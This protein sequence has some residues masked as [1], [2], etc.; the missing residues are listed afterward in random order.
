ML[1]KNINH[2]EGLNKQ[3]EPFKD[4]K[5]LDGMVFPI[6]YYRPD[7]SYIPVFESYRE[8]IIQ[9]LADGRITPTG[10]VVSR[11]NLTPG[12]VSQIGLYSPSYCPYAGGI[13]N[14]IESNQEFSDSKPYPLSLLLLEIYGIRRYKRRFYLYYENHYELVSDE[15]LKQIIRDTLLGLADRRGESGYADEILKELKHNPRIVVTD[16]EICRDK[17]AFRNCCF[18]LK[19]MMPVPP[20]RDDVI[21]YSINASFLPDVFYNEAVRNASTPVFDGFLNSV[22]RHDP[23]LS[24]RIWQTFGYVI[25]PDNYGRAFFVLQGVPASGKSTIERLLIILN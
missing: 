9:W 5:V 11:L 15:T 18:D 1:N 4:Q 7:G 2:T 25:T 12:E 14:S 10:R 17:V 20:S 8:S 24:E 6:N 19:T 23:L 13:L 16:K 22:G 21:M 3:T